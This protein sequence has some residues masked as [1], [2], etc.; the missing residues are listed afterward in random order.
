VTC[1][2]HGSRIRLEDGS[3]EQGPAAY[4]QPVLE[5]RISGGMVEVRDEAP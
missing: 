2:W 1:P 3:V 5:T 4:P